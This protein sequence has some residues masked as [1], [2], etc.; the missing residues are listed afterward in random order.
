MITR[1]NIYT[2]SVLTDKKIVKT[3]GYVKGSTVQTKNVGRDIAAA[4]KTLFGGEIKGY[5][6]MMD[7]ARKIA[8]GR[9]VQEAEELGANAIIA[10]R[11]QTSA[12]MAGAAEII[13]YGTAVLVE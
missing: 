9:L 8:V 10:F 11:L 2:A 6:E 7:Q 5:T 1:E 13:A 3:I 12:V 4:F